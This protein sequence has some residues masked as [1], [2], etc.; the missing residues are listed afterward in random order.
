M[1]FDLRLK[2][3]IAPEAM[4]RAVRA[5]L[6]VAALSLT[7]T[8]GDVPSC[9]SWVQ[10]SEAAPKKKRK[11]R[12]GIKRTKRRRSMRRKAASPVTSVS[13]TPPPPGPPVV[14][15][16]PRRFQGPTRIDFDDRLIQGQTNRSGAVYLFDRKETGIRSMV[17][18]RRTFKA[19]TIQTIYDRR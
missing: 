11:K 19:L 9:G 1:Q 16:P 18:R 10:E 12:K 5:G 8:I 17:R 6:F 13:D 2:P 14:P 15:S 3:P 7:L 4:L